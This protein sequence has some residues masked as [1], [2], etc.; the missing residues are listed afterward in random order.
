MPINI[1]GF[2]YFDNHT[3]NSFTAIDRNVMIKHIK[4]N[5]SSDLSL[6]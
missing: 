6:F 2:V 1:Y 4:A 3:I 5:V